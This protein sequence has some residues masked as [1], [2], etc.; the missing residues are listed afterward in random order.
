MTRYHR[1]C[2]FSAEALA[3]IALLGFTNYTG[4]SKPGGKAERIAERYGG[5]ALTDGEVKEFFDNSEEC[6]ATGNEQ[7]FTH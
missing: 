1:P 7:G 4:L 6:W 3:E 5:R 2:R